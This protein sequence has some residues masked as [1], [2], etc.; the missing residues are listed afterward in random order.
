VGIGLTVAIVSLMAKSYRVSLIFNNSKFRKIT[1]PAS[2]FFMVVLFATCLEA[3][4]LVAWTIVAPLKYVRVLEFINEF[5]QPVSS[6][7]ICLGPA[8]ASGAFVGCLCALH[9]VLIIV[10]MRITQ[11]LSRVPAKY[12]ETRWIN[13]AAL[14]T[15]QVYLIGL[16]SAVAV[17]GSPIGRFLVLSTVTFISC[18][19]LLIAMFYPKYMMLH[20]GEDYFISSEVSSLMVHSPKNN[21]NSVESS[22]NSRVVNENAVGTKSKLVSIVSVS[23]VDVAS[24][25]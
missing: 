9:G 14:S 22:K 3:A 13:I 20:Y 21:N 8:P 11:R 6:Y 2:R 25:A 16:P 15:G 18:A 19:V 24:D 1:A 4:L 5:N 17:Y 12:Q 23:R 7:G 10:T